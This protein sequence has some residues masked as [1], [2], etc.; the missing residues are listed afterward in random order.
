MRALIVAII[1]LTCVGGSESL[2]SNTRETRTWYPN[3]QL[4]ERRHFRDGR[5]EGL[6]QAWTEDGV[7]YMNYEMKSGRRYGFANARPCSPVKKVKL[8]YYDSPDFT[9]RWGAPVNHR[10]EAFDLVAQTGTRFSDVDLN[11]RVHIAS[12]IYTRCSGVCPMM[13]QQLSKVQDALD[14]RPGATLVSF[15]VTPQNDTPELLAKFGEMKGIDPARWKL[16]TGSAEQ[17]YNLARTSYFADDGRL[18]G[19][20]PAA[21]QF[22][23]TEKLLLVDQTGRLRGVYNGTLS[24]EIDKLI[25]DLDTLI[26]KGD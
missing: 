7:L 24:H 8:P 17:I 23:H 9:P 12:F 18:N 1:G 15:S 21:E 22:L 26:S 5:E 10:I 13:V 19:T 3:G 20:Q 11:G 4:A 6:Q 2:P 25:A 14:T 16:L